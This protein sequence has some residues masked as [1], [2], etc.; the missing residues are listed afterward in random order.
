MTLLNRRLFLTAATACAL[1]MGACDAKAASLLPAPAVDTTVTTGA[2][3]VV[4]AGGCFWGVQ[5][6]FA[7]V[8]GVTRAVS[9]YSGGAKETAVYETVGTGRT[10]HAES[11]YVSWD[12][13]QISFGKILQIFFTVA[14]DPTELNR[15]G[16]DVGTQ[17]RNE[18]FT[19][20][21]DQD[22]V[23]RAYIA[24]L[25]RAKAFPEKIVT[26]VG[27]NKGFFAAED[28]HQDYL[29]LHPNEP[30]IVFNDQP[31]VRDLK[32]LFAANWREEPLRVFPPASPRKKA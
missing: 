23:A 32:R 13:K 11:V 18:I 9:G 27:P 3:S 22:R 4:L 21:A 14:T 29:I 31:K 8:K 16:P 28:Y 7:H 20:S 19:M 30:Y 15:Q 10:G 26:K 17:Y 6:V 2:D 24:Q 5:A 25:D 12:P 1:P